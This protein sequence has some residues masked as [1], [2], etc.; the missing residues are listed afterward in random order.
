MKAMSRIFLQLILALSLCAGAATALAQGPATAKSE[1]TALDR[2]VAAPDPSY[3]YELVSSIP[4]PGYTAYVI[5]L[6]SQT[7]RSPNEVDRTVWK[8]WLTIVKPDDVK[9]SKAF[10]YITGGNNNGGAPKSADEQMVQIAT[11]TQSIVAE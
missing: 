7:W 9:F 2:Y 6:T 8:H 4:G 11:M 1:L 5:E 10:L 3:K